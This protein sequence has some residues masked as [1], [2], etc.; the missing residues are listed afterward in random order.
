M[1]QYSKMRPFSKRFPKGVYS[2]GE[3]VDLESLQKKID[4]MIEE[5]CTIKEIHEKLS[6]E[7]GDK[8]YVTGDGHKLNFIIFAT[9]YANEK[10]IQ[11]EKGRSEMDFVVD[12]F[13]PKEKDKE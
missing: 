12:E 10:M 3:K 11:S 6:K 1:T 7:L 5:D 4:S 2:D 13:L 8:E 9:G